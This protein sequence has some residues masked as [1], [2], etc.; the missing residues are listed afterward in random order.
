MNEDQ[1]RGYRARLSATIEAIDELADEFH[2]LGADNDPRS[3]PE[4]SQ[5]GPESLPPATESLPPES[6]GLPSVPASSP[7]VTESPSPAPPPAPESPTPEQDSG[8]FGQRPASLI[9]TLLHRHIEMKE[10]GLRK[11]GQESPVE[12]LPPDT[13]SLPPV[14]ESSP[15]EPNSGKFGQ[16]LAINEPQDRRGVLQENH[17]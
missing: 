3:A 7:P 6:G 10:S 15:P 1:L 9:L 13:G 17:T 12:D 5:P 4:S 16:V 11:I 2:A 14:P 8:K